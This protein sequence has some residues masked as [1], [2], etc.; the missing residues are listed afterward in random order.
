MAKNSSFQ[1][2]CSKSIFNLSKWLHNYIFKLNL[3][4]AFIQI[5]NP[6]HFHVSFWQHGSNSKNLYLLY[7]NSIQDEKERITLIFNFLVTSYVKHLNKWIL[8]HHVI[9][10]LIIIMSI[11]LIILISSQLEWKQVFILFNIRLKGK[12]FF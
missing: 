6:G 11:I 7:E 1:N 3:K 2:F 5:F 10:I 12:K 8:N 9:K 4:I